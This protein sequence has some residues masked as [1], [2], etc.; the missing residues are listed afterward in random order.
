MKRILKVLT[1]FIFIFLLSGCSLSDTIFSPDTIR[2]SVYPIE[3]I[4]D[5]LYGEDA[6]VLSIY[7]D[8]A[9]YNTYDL[10]NKLIETYS[11]ADLLI[12]NGASEENK[13]A[14]KFLNN[15]EEIQI[16]D[17]MQ[18]MSY[19]YGVEELWLDPSNFLMVASNIK[20]GLLKLS[21]N[22]QASER[23]VNNYEELKVEVSRIDVELNTMA[24]T[25]SYSDIVSSNDLLKFLSKYELNVKV[26]NE[27]NQYLSRTYDEVKSLV[28]SGKVKYIYTLKGEE[29]SER[30]QK[31]IDDN[32]IERIELDPITLITE[33]QRNNSENYI[34]IMNE[35]VSKIKKELDK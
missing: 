8:G 20:N 31:F 3:F 2:T 4:T 34:T 23:I 1:C 5:Y 29:L 13:I 19:K 30:L 24:S 32:N 14:V 28:S 27:S 12:Y 33:E 15:N 17:A 11:N 6:K 26:L 10:T 35:N 7:P 22:K 16:I 21:P 25:S 9:D 18:G